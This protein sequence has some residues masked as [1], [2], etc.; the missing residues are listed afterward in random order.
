MHIGGS[1]IY[2]LYQKLFF[3]ICSPVGI[4]TS[5]LSLLKCNFYF[6][7]KKVLRSFLLVNVITKLLV[8]FLSV[9]SMECIRENT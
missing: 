2:L 3:N 1:N 4:L 9:S 7:M 8:I 5:K 6:A